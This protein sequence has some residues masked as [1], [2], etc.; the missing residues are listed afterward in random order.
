[1]IVVQLAVVW[2]YS[3]RER[4]FATDKTADVVS[5]LMAISS[6]G[7]KIACTLGNQHRGH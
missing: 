1:M 4:E 6:L 2:G 3:R 5:L 7:G